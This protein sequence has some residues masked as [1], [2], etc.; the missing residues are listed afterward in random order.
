MWDGLSRTFLGGLPSK[1]HFSGVV[2]NYWDSSGHCFPCW[3]SASCWATASTIGA[4]DTSKPCWVLCQESVC[5]CAHTP[6][7]KITFGTITLVFKQCSVCFKVSRTLYM[8]NTVLGLTFFSIVSI[9]NRS[10]QDSALVPTGGWTW[11]AISVKHSTDPGLGHCYW[12]KWRFLDGSSLGMH[13]VLRG[14][15]VSIV[16]NLMWLLFLIFSMCSTVWPLC[17]YHSESSRHHTPTVKI[18]YFK[19]TT[20]TQIPEV[21]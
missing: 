21:V 10:P 17:E 9:F 18:C 3:W 13:L 19:L 15:A 16:V 4:S 11:G 14:Y 2:S 6:A 5:A 7:C 20:P 1:Q 12:I 8:K